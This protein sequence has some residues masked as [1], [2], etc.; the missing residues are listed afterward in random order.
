MLC[1]AATASLANQI[2]EDQQF[3]I[4]KYQKQ[5]NIIPPEEALINTDPEPDLT[6]D[7]VPLYDGT[8][9]K[10][11]TPKGGKCTFEP[12]GDTIVGTCIPGSP[13][14]YLMT[15][16]SYGDFIFTVEMKWEV[17]GNSG[18]MIRAA[19]KPGEKFE[20]VFGPQVEMEGFEG[21]DGKRKWSGGIY[22]QGYAAWIY[23]LWLDAHQDARAAL[24]IGEW[25]RLTIHA[26]GDT[27]KTWVNGVAAAHWV[28]SKFLSGQLGLQ[29]HSGKKGTILFRNIKVKEL[30]PAPH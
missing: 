27:V 9:L 10:G 6:T 7:F 12:K 24:K 8:S 29:V 28:D 16:K 11:W 17:D 20:T 14:T 13:S 4:K 2:S 3:F 18:V 21:H 22:G 15:D 5:K 23:P 19:S 30:S 1:T 25:N 26:S